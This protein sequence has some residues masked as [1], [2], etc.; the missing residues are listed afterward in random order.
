MLLLQ[1]QMYVPDMEAG[2]CESEEE[3]LCFTMLPNLSIP[4]FHSKNVVQREVTC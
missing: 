4:T 2:F 1:T 3:D